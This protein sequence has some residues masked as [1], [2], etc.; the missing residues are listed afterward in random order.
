MQAKRLNIRTT[1]AMQFINIDRQLN[2]I[3]RESGV[4]DGLCVIFVPHTTAAVTVNENADPDVV[5]DLTKEIN[6]IVPFN[7]SYSH[8]EGNSAA[9]IKSSMIGPSITLVIENGRLVY[10]TWQS[11][12]FC[13]FD[14][15]RSRSCIV[16]VCPD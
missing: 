16:K 14:G 12:Y 3:I 10:G 7:D 1:Q 13:E 5:R 11:L 2:E 4:Q 6:K 15:P 8:A 9:H